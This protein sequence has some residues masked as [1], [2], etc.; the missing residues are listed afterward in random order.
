VRGVIVAVLLGAGVAVELASVLGVLLLRDAFDR[1]HFTAP[2]TTLGPLAI[3]AAVVLRES[4]S[5]ADI[6]ALL[7][8]VV[9]LVTNPVLTHATARAARIRAHGAWTVQEGEEVGG[10]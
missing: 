1:L 3:A 8:A 7:V 4:F 6:K 10:S 2:A 5:Q 9:L